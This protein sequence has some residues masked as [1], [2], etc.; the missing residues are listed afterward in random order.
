[1]TVTATARG[2]AGC[3]AVPLSAACENALT[4]PCSRW[5]TAMDPGPVSTL[6]S[7]PVTPIG[8]RETFAGRRVPTT[9]TV[10]RRTSASRSP[11]CHAVRTESPAVRPTTACR[12]S[13][14][15]GC[16][17]TSPAM[18]P[19]DPA[20]WTS[21]ESARCTSCTPIRKGSAEPAAHAT[22]TAPVRRFLQDR[23]LWT[24]VRQKSLRPVA[25]M[26]CATD[27]EPAVSTE[28]PRSVGTARALGGPS[29]PLTTV[30]GRGSVL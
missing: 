13:A 20:T 23:I 6:G 24:T 1:M 28:A 26:G 5:T 3:G 9:P 22:A 17:A 14:R 27:R 25:W 4:A 29:T 7:W 19:V 30:T 12:D 18:L 8:A 10:L 16:A 15:T 11:V 2:L 21:R